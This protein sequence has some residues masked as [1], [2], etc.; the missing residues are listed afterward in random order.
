M[1]TGAPR[2]RTDLHSEPVDSLVLQLTGTKRW[3]LVA[4]SESRFV[5]PSLSRDGRA[6]FVSTSPTEHPERTLGHVHRRVVDTRPGDALWVPS[7]TWHR[8][9]YYEGVTALSAS[10]FQVRVQALHRNAL[11]SALVVPNILK[12]VVGWKTQ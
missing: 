7:W 4:P 9:D 11:Y 10:L 2:A 8:V 12:E 6:Y 3:L 1:A 5:R